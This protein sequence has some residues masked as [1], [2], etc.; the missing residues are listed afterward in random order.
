MSFVSN[1]TGAFFDRSLGQMSRLRENIEGLQ[2]QIST[3]VRIE[4]GSDDPVGASRLRSLTR[5]EV[6]G[7]TE[8]ENAARLGQDLSESANEIEGVVSILQRA[9]ELAVAASN[10]PTGENGRAAIADELEQMADELFARSNARS[11]T[12]APLF[13]GT[14]GAPAYVRD[15]TGVVT[16]N[17]NGQSGAVPVAPD[18]E[19]ERG[20]AGPQV[21][22]FDN[23]GSP[24]SAFAAL[25]ELAAAM[26]NPGGDPAQAG[27]DA[28]ARIDLS[29]DTANRAQTVIGARAAWVEAIRQDQDLRAINV[30]EKRSAIEDTDIAD[31]IVR[32]QQT[33]TALEASQA[34]FTRISSLT[35]FNAL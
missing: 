27:R 14:A 2:T 7:N 32:L 5:L 28:I 34:S 16:Y 31:T 19:I 9:R 20:L 29:L 24:D 8:N 18:T 25:S 1:S 13:A 35:L 10:D 26:R 11:I 3:G 15:T 17:G 30:A 33:L 22:Q 6:R 21:F 12:G 4:L 23:N